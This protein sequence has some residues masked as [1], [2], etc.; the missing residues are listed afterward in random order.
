MATMCSA[1]LARGAKFKGFSQITLG[2]I[3]IKSILYIHTSN[4]EIIMATMTLYTI[5][6]TIYYMLYTI[7][8]ILHTTYYILYTIYYI[9]YDIYYILYYTILDSEAPA[10]LPLQGGRRPGALSIHIYIYIYIY[11]YT[12]T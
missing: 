2:E 4:N 9:L 8:Y 1:D 11:I 7:Y 12:H 6:Y 10:V 3:I 5:L